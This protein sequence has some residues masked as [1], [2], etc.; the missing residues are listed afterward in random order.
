MKVLWL[1]QGGL[2]FVS[3]KRKVMIDPYLTNSL[4]LLDYTLDRKMKVNKKI[5]SVRPEVIILT[6]CHPDHADIDTITKFAKKQKDKLTILSC[7]SVFMD[8]AD[9]EHIARANNILFEAGSEWSIDG[10][11]IRAVKAKTDDRSAFGVVITDTLTSKKYYVAGDTL[12]SEQVLK[13]LPNDIYAGFLPINGRHGSMNALDA[14]RFASNLGAVH[15][16]PVHFGMIDNIDPKTLDLD[17]V[18]IPEIYKIIDFEANDIPSKKLID[19]KFNE[20]VAP[21]STV[22]EVAKEPVTVEA[23]E[24]PV[25]EEVTE[26]PVAVEAT[27]EP[28]AEEIAEEPVIEEVAGEPV[29]VEATEEP[30]TEE[31]TEEPVAVEATEEPVAVE[32][33]EEPVIVEDNYEESYGDEEIEDAD[34]TP[35]DESLDKEPYDEDVSS[36][37]TDFDDEEDDLPSDDVEFVPFTEEELMSFADA[38]NEDQNDAQGDKSSA[39]NEENGA[40]ELDANIDSQNYE[41]ESSV[42]GSTDDGIM[43]DDATDD[44]ATDDSATTDDTTSDAP[45]CTYSSKPTSTEDDDA[46]IIDAYVK[47]LEKLDRGETPKF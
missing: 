25:T 31:V 15:I 2:L 13:D 4:S 11:N 7:E 14:K 3:G 39:S 9:Y 41:N 43:D 33:T 47:E 10:F 8:I 12:Y 5:F 26:E 34:D 44:D 32:A 46:E 24:E 17:N 20:R 18:I 22:E 40:N 27:E 1:G 35:T 28:V 29:A 30:A 16:V 21:S 23:N 42:D 45:V 37:Y 19:R 38:E 36:L 6:N